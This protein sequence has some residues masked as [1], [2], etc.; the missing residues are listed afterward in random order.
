MDS[1]ARVAANV[2]AET[3]GQSPQT[4]QADGESMI[5]FIAKWRGE[6]ISLDPVPLSGTVLL[7]KVR[8][9]EPWEAGCAH[10]MLQY[11]RHLRGLITMSF[12]RPV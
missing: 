4:P 11:M 8:G 12:Q 6:E 5:D 1:E 9:Q 7:L 3:E 2:A 10:I